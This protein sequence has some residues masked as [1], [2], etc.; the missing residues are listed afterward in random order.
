M[1]IAEIGNAAPDGGG[2][3]PK[4]FGLVDTALCGHYLAV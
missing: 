2:Y 3:L 1:M 4:R